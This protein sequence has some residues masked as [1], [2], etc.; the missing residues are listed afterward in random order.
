S[1]KV[2]VLTI[3][4]AFVAGIAV[5]WITT[6]LP[7]W[8]AALNAPAPDPDAHVTATPVPDPSVSV[9]PL[10]PIFRDLNEDDRRAGLT[11]LDYEYIGTGVFDVVPG[12]EEE[13]AGGPPTRWV[14]VSVEGGLAV[15]QELFAEF[16]MEALNDPRGWGAHGRLQ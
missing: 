10:E 4:G 12:V 13:D 9:P 16:V 6:L 3:L 5:A 14:S 15:D 1:L 2:T 11:S 7:G 8:I